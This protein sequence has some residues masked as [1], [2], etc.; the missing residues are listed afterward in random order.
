MAVEKTDEERR[1]PFFLNAMIFDMGVTLGGNVGMQTLEGTTGVTV[2]YQKV[3][4]EV[5]EENTIQLNDENWA[6][7]YRE[8]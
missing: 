4:E 3:H 5:P 1:G 8:R 2:Y 7:H 6:E